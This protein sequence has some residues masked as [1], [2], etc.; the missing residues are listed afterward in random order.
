M[1]GLGK[2]IAAALITLGVAGAI[3]FYVYNMPDTE[4]QVVRSN[5]QA[6]VKQQSKSLI[7]YSTFPA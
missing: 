6:A 1:E 4:A 2:K 3:G 7:I 5:V